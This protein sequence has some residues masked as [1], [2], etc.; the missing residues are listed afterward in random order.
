MTAPQ[1]VADVLATG[2]FLLDRLVDH[3]VRMTSDEDAREWFGHVTPAMERFRA[4][5]RAAAT[6]ARQ[7]ETK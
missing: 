7:G 1:T 2:R 3:E 4:A 5:L 6:S